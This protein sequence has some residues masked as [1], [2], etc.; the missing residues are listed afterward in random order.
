MGCTVAE[1]GQRMSAQ[2]FG[3]W[4]EFLHAEP[5]PQHTMVPMLAQLLAA[6]A[7]GPLKPPSGSPV[8]QAQHFMPPD[9]WA[10]PPPPVPEPT[11]ADFLATFNQR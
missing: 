6:L 2:E 3:D 8:W 7:N 11:V 5:A 1:L 10:P 4:C 9:P